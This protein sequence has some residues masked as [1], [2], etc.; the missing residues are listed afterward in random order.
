MTL[1]DRVDPS[2]EVGE[3]TGADGADVVKVFETRT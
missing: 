3:T 1:R 2:L